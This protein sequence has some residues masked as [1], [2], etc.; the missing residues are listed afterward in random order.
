MLSGIAFG[1]AS[2][3]HEV[4][5]ITSR[6]RYDKPMS[7]LPARETI[8]GVEVIRIATTRFG[9]D[10][11]IGRAVDYLTFYLSAILAVL[12]HARRGD[13][14]V[15]KTDPPML[16]VVLWPIAALRGARL[17]NWLQDIFPE[18]AIALGVGS[19]GAGKVGFT[20][21]SWLRNLSLRRAA[22]NVVLGDRMAA[23]VASLGVDGDRI[24]IVPNWADG[25]LIGPVTPQANPL[26]A[27]WGLEDTFV[28][29]YSGNLGRAHDIATMLAAIEAVEAV[30][31][32]VSAEPAAPSPTDP[33]AAPVRWLFIGSGAQLQ[34]L[35]AGVAERGLTSVVFQPYQPQERLA[36]SLSVPDL[37]LITLKPELEGLIV[38]SKFYGI[39]A[40]GR[41][42]IFIGDPE[43]EIARI[44]AKHDIGRVVREG[45]SA[46][47]AAA[48]LAMRDDADATMKSGERARSLFE[49][50]FDLPQ[51]VE[52]WEDVIAKAAGGAR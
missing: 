36:Q 19:R 26:R 14:V 29:G 35:K 42:A 30:A 40:A 16:S 12:H 28:V 13:V 3:G 31:S 11:L 23:H 15:A 41:P 22:L 18:V 9:R 45:D 48:V 52:M 46:A 7:E 1:L 39:T 6:Q 37:H 8:D 49:A 44:V 43:G 20:L 17:V 33:L 34:A 51:A 25:T 10:R 27:A 38:P 4:S 21:L 47:L 24:A 50:A 2:R 32:P 5:V